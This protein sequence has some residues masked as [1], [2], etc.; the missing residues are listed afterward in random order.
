MSSFKVAPIFEL[1]VLK[2]YLVWDLGGKRLVNGIHVS[3]L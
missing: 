1:I 2:P 3:N